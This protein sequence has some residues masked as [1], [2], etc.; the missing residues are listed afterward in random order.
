MGQ[1]S[2]WGIGYPVLIALGLFAAGTLV[3]QRTAWGQTVFA[4]GRA[5]TTGGTLAGV[6]LLGAIQ[7]VINQVGC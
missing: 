1:G 2:L 6:V 4:I 3:L 5:G 7:S